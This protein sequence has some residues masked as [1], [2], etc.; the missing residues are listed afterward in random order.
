MVDRYNTYQQIIGTLRRQQDP[1]AAQPIRPE[2]YPD[3]EN[4]ALVYLGKL[5]EGASQRTMTKAL[6]Q[7]VKIINEKA[8]S[9]FDYLSFPWGKLR[10][11]TTQQL[12]ALIASKYPSPASANHLLYA[13]RGVLKAAWRLGQMTAE[14]YH[15]AADLEVIRG[16]SVPAGRALSGGE[17]LALFKAC[18]KGKPVI[19]ARDA[20]MIALLYG[21]GLR[22][23]EI[24]ALR[25]DD[26]RHDEEFDRHEVLVRGKGKKQRL[27]PITNGTVDAMRAWLRVRGTEPGAMFLPIT[28]AGQPINEKVLNKKGELVDRHLSALAVRMMLQHRAKQAGVK[29]FSPHDLRRTMIGDLLD[30]GADIKAVSDLVGHAEIS[31]TAK[32][33]RRGEAAKRRAAGLLNVPY[34]YRK[35]AK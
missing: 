35:E 19:G 5:A 27:L 22:R 31:T 10:F 13:L 30:A 24:V 14:E 4:P 23:S 12:R 18:A 28:Y 7:V 9:N 11:Q 26:Y 33:D 32:Y 1:K 16:E 25:L 3:E 17:I 6:Q 34:V 29:K 8:N 21:G 20:A 2:E 15:N